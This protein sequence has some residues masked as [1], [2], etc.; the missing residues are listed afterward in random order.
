[1]NSTA[2]PTPQSQINAV[3][4]MRLTQ[5][6]IRKRID[7]QLSPSDR[8][9]AHSSED[10][11]MRYAR[12]GFWT[13]TLAGGMLA[14]RSRIMAGR[15]AMQQGSLPRLFYPTKPGQ[16]GKLEEE[17]AK[18]AAKADGAAFKEQVKEK[19]ADEMRRSKAAFFGKAIGYGILGSFIGCVRPC[20]FS[21]Q[22]RP[23]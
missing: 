20:H 12:V 19:S 1:M 13:G 10:L 15:R 8:L 18:N 3:E 23:R 21:E 7:E 5:E 9:I 2:P 14:F 4:L 6:T 22:E 17:L 11:V 16:A